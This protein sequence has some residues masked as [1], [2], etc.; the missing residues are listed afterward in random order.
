MMAEESALNGVSFPSEGGTPDIATITD[1]P[2]ESSD[3]SMIEVVLW[4]VL[5]I[6]VVLAGLFGNVI[7][8]WVVGMH[9]T[10]HTVTNYFLVNLSISDI[11]YTVLNMPWYFLANLYGQWLFGS[12][13]KFCKL[14]R[15]VA[16]M[17]AAASTFSMTA[18]SIDRYF[19]IVNPLSHQLTHKKA[20]AG[21]ATIWTLSLITAYPQFHFSDIV[22]T[23]PNST[24]P[25]CL[26]IFPDGLVGTYFLVT[27]ILQ[28][29]I[30]LVVPG[31]I[32]STAYA[33]VARE[34]WDTKT[35][36]ETQNQRQ[37][38]SKRK[39]V[40]MMITIAV[41]FNITMIPA[42]L[43]LIAIG[44][45][46]RILDFGQLNNIWLFVT[47]LANSNTVYN[48]IIYCYMNGRFRR[49]FRNFFR[50]LLCK[51]RLD[52]DI[53]R[54]PATGQEMRSKTSGQGKSKNSSTILS[55]S[56]MSTYDHSSSS[57]YHQPGTSSS[58]S[59]K[60]STSL[61]HNLSPS[62]KNSTLL[63][64]D[65]CYFKATTKC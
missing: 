64:V 51:R 65:S 3:K 53:V 39:I 54:N 40:K 22:H 37:I 41:V 28:S 33:V 26:M 14:V 4:S 30:Y 31:I 32:I 36:G 27:K 62:F 24:A 50:A 6:S 18:I 21:I 58:R 52:I 12:D 45:D 48:P 63:T 15:L 29:L 9:K 60:N 20:W 42:H 16:P 43:V 61:D 19:A 47:L 44:I 49:G 8:I 10:M 35:I 34:L 1:P 59:H 56:V 2:E 13:A 23:G 55:T 57:V 17:S 38:D 5:Y 11:M 46:N 7:V 25:Q